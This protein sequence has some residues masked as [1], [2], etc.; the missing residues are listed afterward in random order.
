MRGAVLNFERK[1][2]DVLDPVTLVIKLL[3]GFVLKSEYLM[4]DLRGGDDLPGDSD[5]AVVAP[6]EYLVIDASGQLT[7]ID[8]LDDAK[9]FARY[10]FADEIT[11]ATRSGSGGPGGG[12]PGGSGTGLMPG[13]GGGSM[14]PGTGAGGS[15][16]PGTGAPGGSGRG[17]RRGS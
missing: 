3:E 12:Y 17:G 7:V 6:G 11:A 2:F 5:K 10:T 13:S 15:M 9:D 1:Q 14:L 8:E 16:L 4:A